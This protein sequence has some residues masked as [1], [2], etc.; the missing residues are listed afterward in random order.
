VRGEI[1]MQGVGTEVPPDERQNLERIAAVMLR[2]PSARI[3][4]EGEDTTLTAGR[5][6]VRL[7]ARD[8]ETVQRALIALGIARD[9]MTIALTGTPHPTCGQ[10]AECRRGRRLVR[11]RL[12]A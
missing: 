11:I 1:V 3:V 10:N 8:A 12:A 9:R 7:G 5:E 4:I 6:T 2:V